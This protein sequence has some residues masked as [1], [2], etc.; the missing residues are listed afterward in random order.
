MQNEEWVHAGRPRILTDP[1]SN[2]SYNPMLR[3]TLRE[4][5]HVMCYGLRNENEDT[6]LTLNETNNQIDEL[7]ESLHE[8]LHF[9][10]GSDVRRIVEMEM[11]VCMGHTADILQNIFD[12]NRCR[13]KSE[14][15]ERIKACNNPNMV[16]KE[17]L[18]FW[19]LKGA[20]S[21]LSKEIWSKEH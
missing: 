18:F 2:T 19:M 9:I 7:M 6:E 12:Y 8:F 21:R 11:G 17:P 16:C 15:L 3:E 1:L 13:I 20:L 4:E 10:N 14:I 5:D